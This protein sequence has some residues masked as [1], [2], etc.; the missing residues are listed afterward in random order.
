MIYPLYLNIQL[1]CIQ[2]SFKLNICPLMSSSNSFIPLYLSREARLFDMLFSFHSPSRQLL[3]LSQ[4]II[5]MLPLLCPA[6]V[7]FDVF[8][9]ADLR[10]ASVSPYPTLFP[11]WWHLADRCPSF[12]QSSFSFDPFTFRF[13][14]FSTEH[15]ILLRLFACVNASIASLLFL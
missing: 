4:F 13:R 7:L 3:L 10:L 1:L 9:L 15:F 8:V 11:Y 14:L 12:E 6:T 5:S 2:M